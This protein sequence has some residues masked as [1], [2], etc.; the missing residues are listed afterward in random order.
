MNISDKIK[1]KLNELGLANLNARPYDS[2]H[3]ILEGEP[4]SRKLIVVGFNGSNA[5][6]E[7]TNI[8]AIEHGEQKPL[9]S[10]VVNGANGGWLSTTL[11]KRLLS[12]PEELGFD[13]NST[14]F[15][16]AILLCSENANAVKRKA[17]SVGFKS[18]NDLVEKSL[19]FLRM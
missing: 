2:S 13:I 10:N 17:V 19:D 6:L 16:N 8:S 14:V 18:V 7:W 4:S 12:I 5:D 1:N 9:D 11:P 15:T 3:S